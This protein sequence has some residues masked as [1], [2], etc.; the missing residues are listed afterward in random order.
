MKKNELTYALDSCRKNPLLF[1]YSLLLDM[2]FL[3]TYGLLTTPIFS[4]LTEHTILIASLVSSQLQ[5][6]RTNKSLIDLLFSPTIAPFVYQ[7]FLLLLLLIALV[8]V[9]YCLFQGASWK[10]A[11]QIAGNK[12]EWNKH[13]IT[14]AKTNLFWLIILCMY[15]VIDLVLKIRQTILLTSNQQ[16]NPS[17]VGVVFGTIL[18]LTIFYFVLLSYGAGSIKKAWTAGIK[19]WK[20]TLPAF[21]FI[22]ILF[23]II[24]RILFFA[25]TWRPEVAYVLGIVLFLP[26]LTWTKVYIVYIVEALK[27]HGILS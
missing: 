22:I 2:F 27:K 23:T 6:Q 16:Y 18:M 20:Q 9:L 5:A 14:F 13:L 21:L 4:K 12:W 1:L 17:I 10:F 19:G 3:F 25:S 26:A 24:D 8:Y 15:S 11:H 7:F